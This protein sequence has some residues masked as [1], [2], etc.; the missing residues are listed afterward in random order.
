MEK[1]AII[2]PPGAGKTTLAKEI[3]VIFGIRACHLDR[4]F[5]QPGWKGKTGDKRIDILQNFVLRSK[6]II[7]GT[8]LRSSGPR[9]EAAD[10]I[11]FLDVNPLLCL[12]RIIIRY[13]KCRGCIRRRDI[14]EGCRDKLT[15]YRMLKVLIFPLWERRK[16]KHM[17]RGY[18]SKQIIEFHS[19]KEVED[20]LVRLGAS[21]GVVPA[22]RT[23][24]P[25]IAGR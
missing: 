5:W 12:L 7:E 15:P 17:L 22:T 8:Y 10:T 18:K 23:K 21:S 16:L 1:I 6:W 19:R 3:A 9:L 2:G 20:F 13:F 11:I 25:V 24:L 4:L 14:P